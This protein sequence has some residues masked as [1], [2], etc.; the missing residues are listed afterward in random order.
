MV[1]LHHMVGDAWTLAL[2]GSQFNALLSG[3]APE[4]YSYAE[5]LEREDDYLQSGRYEKD[6]AYFLERFKTCDEVTFLSEKRSEN[7]A[8]MFVNTAPLLIELDNAKAFGENL[9]EVKSA[10]FDLF[11][12]QK[13]NYGELLSAL[14]GSTVSPGGLRRDGQLPKRRHYRGA[15]WL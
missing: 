4:A 12:H 8:G 11:R 3:E 10:S 14:R 2:L 5:Y 6:R 15:R 7:T 9:E 13:Y 1:K